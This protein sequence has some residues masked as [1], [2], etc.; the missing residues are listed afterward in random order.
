MSSQ[1]ASGQQGSGALGGSSF[2]GSGSLSSSSQSSSLFSQGPPQ[3]GSSSLS[4]SANGS[5]SLG[6]AL[7]SLGGFGTAG[8]CVCVCV[9]VWSM[10][11][12]DHVADV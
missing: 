5:S 10:K 1:Q 11:L 12:A 6:A 8:K 3:P 7:G 9:C 2:Y 4:F